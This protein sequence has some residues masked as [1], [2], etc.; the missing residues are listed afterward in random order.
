MRRQWVSLTSILALA[1]TGLG[2][3]WTADTKAKPAGGKPAETSAKPLSEKE[4][5]R[6]QKRL[7]QELQGPFKKW[8]NEDVAYIITD[9]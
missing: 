6:R 7:E 2:P 5:K 3:A 4:M 9:E 8:L 1:W